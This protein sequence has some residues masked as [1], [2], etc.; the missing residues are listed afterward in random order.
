MTYQPSMFLRA[1]VASLTCG[2]S[3]LFNPTA[4]AAAA[5]KS[6]DIPVGAALPALKRFV[7]QSG[8]QLLYSAEAVQGVTTN[9][10]KGVLTARE[11]LDRMVEGTA[12]RVVAD[13]QNGALSLVRVPVPN[14]PRVEPEEATT[15]KSQSKVED[16]KLVLDKFEVFGSKSIN[17]DIPR[18]RDDV[19]P[20]VVFGRDRIQNSQASNLSDFFRTRLPMATQL[21]MNQFTGG[22]ALS[23]TINLR[24]LGAAQTLILVDGRR[25]PSVPNAGTYTS[26]PPDPSAIPLEMIER[27]E[28][29]PSTASGIYG[30]GATG[31][32]IN[33][34]TRKDFSGAVLTLNYVNTFD[35]DTAR[36]RVDLN[37]STSLRGGAT[38]LTLTA[39]WQDANE[40]LVQD[41][42]FATRARQLAFANNPAA[43]TGTSSVPL[44]Y[45]P[46]IRNQNGQNLVLKPQYGGTVLNSAITSVPVGYAGVASDNA[47]A[48]IANAGRYNLNLPADFNGGRGRQLSSAS[49]VT[50]LGFG[51]RQKLAPWLEGYVD[52]L[53]TDTF[54]QASGANGAPSNATLS[55]ANPAN[56]F[57]TAVVVSYPYPNLGL[58]YNNN[59]VEMIVTRL[60]G[61]LVAKLPGDW[62]AGL[63]YV[64]G[65]SMY[66]ARFDYAVL[67]DPDG[68]AGAGLSYNSAVSAGTFDLLRDLNQHPLAISS[69]LVP[70][71]AGLDNY[72]YS[73]TQSATMR[74]SGPVFRLPAGD[75]VVSASAEWR[76]LEIDPSVAVGANTAAPQPTYAY[77][78]GAATT[79]ESVYVETRVPLLA[80]LAGA[81]KQPRLELQ[82]AGRHDAA[83]ARAVAQIK[84]PALSNPAGPYPDLPYNTPHFDSSTYTVGLRYAPL[85]DIAFRASAGSGFLAPNATQLAGSPSLNG[86]SFPSLIDHKRGKVPADVGPVTYLVGGNPALR[87]EQ[88]KSYSGGVVFTPRFWPAFRLSVDYTKINKT[89]EIA[90]LSNQ[91]LFDFEDVLP[92]VLVRAPLTPADQAFGYTG[93]VVTGIK[94]T[95]LNFARREVEAVDVQ[96]DYTRKTTWG[97]FNA[98]AIATWNRRFAGQV[99]PTVPNLNEV[100][101]LSSPLKWRGNVGLDWSR[102]SWSA[103]WNTQFYDSQ[104]IYTVSATAAAIANTV[105]TQGAD[106]WGSQFYHDAQI[107]Y[108]FGRGHEGWRRA[109]SD[110]KVSVGLQNVFNREPPLQAG[111][112][113]RTGFQN[114]ED[115]RLRRYSL[116]IR[117]RF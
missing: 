50:S 106:H 36:R 26:F 38:V 70:G 7:A 113:T 84:F 12:L 48:L 2:L 19:Q 29:L 28:V 9:P 13:K 52:F 95:A 68:P 31:G 47:A 20:Y 41:R 21:G 3:L 1:A 45:T 73:L 44:G 33:I 108:Q 72:V 67:G 116:T 37:A 82:V 39:S 27:I 87:P 57:T 112:G 10:V 90:N 42:D 23:T 83:Q 71:M 53:R 32:V 69:Y 114:I 81:G 11:A 4:A 111:T 109:F 15:P 34:I 30:G 58:Y 75:V 110:L 24:G 49:P 66:D 51:L 107:S 18:T 76:K 78:P 64:W 92:G 77:V 56:P 6:F 89:D 91:Q 103:G 35:T 88:S 17:L 25:L 97:E 115:P 79:N 117:K 59:S 5:T 61:G 55:A 93:G 104:L 94:A 99:V 74:A 96:A 60:T 102:G 101:Y 86:L 98:Y 100:G 16:G 22:N 63:D 80:P 54:T 8:E 43:F 46:N 85:P 14:A 62:Q 65:R 40:L 105:L